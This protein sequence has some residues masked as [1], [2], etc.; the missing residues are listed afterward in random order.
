MSS[1][2]EPAREDTGNDIP[3]GLVG[4]SAS[5]PCFVDNHPLQC[6]LDSGSQV[7]LIPESLCKK[8]EKYVHPLKD[9]ILWHGG[10][11]Q[12]PYIGYTQIDISFELEFTGTDKP[13]ST[14][15]LVIPDNR[16][17]KDHPV[18]V[19]T[20]SGVFR[21]CYHT[22]KRKPTDSINPICSAIYNRIAKNDVDVASLPLTWGPISTEDKQQLLNILQ[23]KSAVFCHDP[24]NMGKT[25]K[26]YHEI[27]MTDETP[28]R[29]RSRRVS[30][31]D[32]EDLREHLQELLEA[33]IIKES[34][35]RYASP[36]VLVRKKTGSYA[37]A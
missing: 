8:L 37:S 30:P 28:F 24:L 9:L 7:T 6:L 4:E 29:E 12:I 31:A 5:Y 13:F 20:N 19:G 10:G 11:G 27:R 16:N 14:L 32:L 33:G 15:A 21:Q 1:Q 3:N 18:V 34:R 36:I 22:Y 23:D 17:T 2:H 26:I 25:D 35:S